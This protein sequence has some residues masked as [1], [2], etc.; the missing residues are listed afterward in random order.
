MGDHN[1]D[2]LAQFGDFDF[3]GNRVC[4]VSHSG[5]RE[6]GCMASRLLSL[7]RQLQI[8]VS[9]SLEH[10]SSSHTGPT[11]WL[12]ARFDSTLVSFESML[13]ACKT[14]VFLSVSDMDRITQARRAGCK[15][16]LFPRVHSIPVQHRK[17]INYFDV[18]VCPNRTSSDVLAPHAAVPK[19]ITALW[20]QGSPLASRDNMLAGVQPELAV[21]VVLDKDNNEPESRDTLQLLELILSQAGGKVK[22]TVSHVQRTWPAAMRRQCQQLLGQYPDHL[23]FE[24]KGCYDK[25]LASM[26]RH[27]A[28]L[29]AARYT[30]SAFVAAESAM[31][32][33]P[34]IAYDLPAISPVARIGYNGK[35][36]SCELDSRFEL[37]V[38]APNVEGLLQ[39]TLDLA[40][41]LDSLRKSSLPLT[42]RLQWRSK[43]ELLLHKVLSTD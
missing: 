4:V 43:F 5:L 42:A 41:N 36:V 10:G 33:K 24:Y 2:A 27:D 25:Y 1:L 28:V 9:S 7:L 12:D 29:W 21:F 34:L 39:A 19:L 14:M 35:L 6:S 38:A 31:A 3:R 30:N 26:Y 11:C 13:H 15:M 32:G 18:V 22:L 8:N 37:P 23:R 20:D 17:R 16:V 40:S